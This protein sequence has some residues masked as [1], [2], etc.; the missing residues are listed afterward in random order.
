MTFTSQL[1]EVTMAPQGVELSVTQSEVETCFLGGE[2]VG[3]MFMSATVTN[4]QLYS[5][6]NNMPSPTVGSSS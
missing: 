4:N 3:E 6:V 2:D 1:S 5:H